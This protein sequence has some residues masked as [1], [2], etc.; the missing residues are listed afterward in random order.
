MDSMNQSP[1][2]VNYREVWRRIWSR[3]S[4]FYKVLPATFILSSIYICALPRYYSTETQM[5][6]ETEN[7]F[8]GGSIGTLASSF[9]IDLNAEGTDAITPMLYPDLLEDN[10]FITS[11]FSIEVENEDGDIHAKYFDYLL[12]YQKKSPW[13][14]PLNWV[15]SLF[16]KSE[17]A[18]EKP[19]DPYFLTKTED[20]I[21]ALIRK[22]ITCTVDKKTGVI[23]IGVTDQDRVICKTIADSTRVHLQ[24]FITEY[25]TNKA[26]VD[27]EYY[28]QLAEQARLNYE[29]ARQRYARFGDSHNG[30]TITSVRS[31]SEELENDMQLKYTTYTTINTQLQAAIAKVQERTPAFT[32]LKGA[33]VPMKPS[34]PKRMIFV[35]VML[36]LATVVCGCY[37]LRDILLPDDKG[38]Q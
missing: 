24:E 27:M 5:A 20:N 25:R 28:S 2:G 3:R 30:N 8:S 10:G 18:A 23:T 37:I 16:K 31:K 38:Q 22:H 17:P 4:L 13:G 34:Q 35:A 7:G 19:L 15:K 1:I 21:A 29:E 36:F 12:K 11:L 6:P 14:A 26:R 9:G 33:A 32:L